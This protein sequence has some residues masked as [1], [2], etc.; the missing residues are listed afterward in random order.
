MN[1]Q[2]NVIFLGKWFRFVY[3]GKDWTLFTTNAWELAD[4]A[5]KRFGWLKQNGNYIAQRI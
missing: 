4:R 3:N 5:A 2:R 1:K